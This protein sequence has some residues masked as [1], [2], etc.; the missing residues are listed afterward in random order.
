MKKCSKKATFR[1][2]FPFVLF[3]FLLVLFISFSETVGYAATYTVEN[4]NDSGPGSLRTA[5]ASA[6]SYDDLISFDVT[7][8]IRLNSQLIL[9]SG[10]KIQGPGA[11][12]LA[13]SGGGKCRVFYIEDTTDLVKIS[14]ISIVSGNAAGYDSSRPGGT[15]GGGIYNQSDN[16]TVSNCTFVLNNADCGGGMFNNNSSFF[17]SAT[18]ANCTFHRN[19]ATGDGGGMYNASN[20]VLEA[21]NCAFSENSAVSGAGICN[22]PDSVLEVTNC[23]FSE[24]R[25]VNG[26]GMYSYSSYTDVTNCTFT[27]N[28]A[29]PDVGGYGGGMHN[30]CCNNYNSIVTNCTFYLNNA[31]YGGGMCNELSKPTITNCT[32]Y[33]NS[34]WNNGGGMYNTES[35]SPILTN[36]ILWENSWGEIYNDSA[37]SP[38]VPTLKCCLI[39]NNDYGE[40]SIIIMPLP[41]LS[42]KLEQ[43]S[44]NGGPTFTCAL[45]EGS[46]A[47]DAGTDIGAPSTDQRGVPR[48]QGASPDVG[49]YEYGVDFYI[50]TDPRSD[51]G[52][53][54][55]C[56][57]STF[58]GMGFLL[59]IP[60]MFLS[61]TRK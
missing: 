56:S 27:L 40:G 53:G 4:T 21:T 15:D 26:G 20:S 47:I 7:G 33:M 24:N 25:A 30:V 32:F 3:V 10:M 52:N 59:L 28:S 42:P 39:Q 12:L 13:V 44:D 58:P 11:D 46:S 17:S 55:G 8:S 18:V 9:Y 41:P 6:D 57:I 19:R 29:S 43:L 37:M 49:A 14:G 51:G 54:D 22:Y 31:G 36:C 45:G 16:L 61:G 23:T 5:I 48:P 34:G 38:F 60:L 2:L 35:S 1:H 50:V